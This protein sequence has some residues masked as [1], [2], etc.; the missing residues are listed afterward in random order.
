MLLGLAGWPEPN[1]TIE[2]CSLIVAA[3]LI[4]ALAVQRSAT[5][6]WA[7]MPLSFVIDFTSLLLLGPNATLLVAGAGTITQGLTDSQ[8]SPLTFR[9]LMNAAT[10]MLAAQAAGLAHLALG[11]TM[12]H[13][14]WPWQGVPIGAAVVAY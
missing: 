7:T 1:R 13:F 6:D 3:I 4:S 14:V 8:R 12:G 5:T 11:G 10:V 9:L 2:F